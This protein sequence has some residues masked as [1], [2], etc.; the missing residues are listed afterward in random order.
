VSAVITNT[1]K[2]AGD[3]IVQ[4]YLHQ[5]HTSRKRPVLELKGFRRIHLDAGERRTVTFPVGF[6]EVKFW[7]DHRW[8]MEPG[9]LDVWIGAASDDIRLRGQVTL[10]H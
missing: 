2:R 5:D 7:K 9:P 10:V 1:G 3:E 8:T 6:E 4:L